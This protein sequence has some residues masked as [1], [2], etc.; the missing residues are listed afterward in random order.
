[1]FGDSIYLTIPVAINTTYGGF[2]LSKKA[3]EL[4]NELKGSKKEDFYRLPRNDDDLIYVIGRLG[5]EASSDGG[6]KL[7]NVEIS[8]DFE[9][10]AGKESVKVSGGAYNR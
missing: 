8:I 5:K 1:M 2:S 3:I 4:L 7:I 10:Y 9:S 6:V